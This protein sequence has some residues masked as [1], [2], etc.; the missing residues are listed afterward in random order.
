MGSFAFRI[1]LLIGLAGPWMVAASTARA[2]DAARSAPP[3]PIDAPVASRTVEHAA[4]PDSASEE[5]AVDAHVPPAAER[6]I[7]LHLS[8]GLALIS[9]PLQ[10]STR[11][12]SGLLPG[13]PAGARA[14]TWSASAQQ[15]VEGFDQ[16]LAL[17]EGALLHLPE[18]AVLT[19][20]GRPAPSSRIPVELANGWNLVGVPQPAPLPLG[21][22]SIWAGG[23]ERPFDDAVARKMV[24]E[25]VFALDA[26]GNGHRRVRG[27]LEP[28]QAY[29][30]HANDAEL[31]TLQPAL[32]KG[33]AQE[34]A[35]W[36]A[37]QA[38]AAGFSY[39]SGQ[40]IASISPDPNQ[41][42]LDKLDA[43]ARQI[44]D[45]QRTQQRVLDQFTLTR[46]QIRM[47][48][49]Q[50]LSAVGEV[51]LKNVRSSVVA[52]FD[53][54]SN[55]NGSLMYFAS[56]AQTAEGRARITRDN[57]LE[58]ARNVLKTWD[59]V[60][61]LNA[62]HEA[63]AP[64]DGSRGVLDYFAEK[65]VLGGADDSTI[66]DRYLAM[67]AYFN[68][69]VGL[70][71]KIMSL[72]TNAWSTLAEEPGSGYSAA[73]AD[74]WRATTYSRNLATQA[75]R[76]RDASERIMAGSLRVAAEI[77]DAPVSFPADVANLIVPRVDFGVM[78]LA[79]RRGC[80]CASSSGST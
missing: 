10:T 24:G 77:T 45:V 28:G 40:L 9:V 1:A 29:W 52:H 26:T 53:D 66:E 27:M 72:L 12:L 16:E 44:E 47:T 71:V 3:L 49:A 74:Q 56:Q 80:A 76:F 78:Q 70:Q 64:A 11:T 58:F 39:L 18:P 5:P 32:L 8:A 69:L 50:I 23:I 20:V 41:P 19:F 21:T 13:L 51:N 79:K 33:A 2:A 14:W 35:W 54:A 61:Q 57:K 55:Q 30:V 17:G 46:T 73:L 68:G 67:E 63:I 75:L 22:Q 42:I 62:V 34:L 15:W 43:M 65:I 6:A 7:R 38:G 36:T 31:L 59:F 60:T 37:K 4:V 48:E 25:R